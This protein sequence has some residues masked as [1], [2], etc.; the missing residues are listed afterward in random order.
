MARQNAS[1][2]RRYLGARS[3]NNTVERLVRRRRTGYLDL[4][5]GV[6]QLCEYHAAD[7]AGFLRKGRVTQD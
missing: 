7:G 4:A 2:C 3:P 6:G 1:L 5:F